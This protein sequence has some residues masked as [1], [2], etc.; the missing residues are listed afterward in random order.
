L[1]ALPDEWASKGSVKG[2]RARGNLIVDFSWANG[3]VTDYRVHGAS[4]KNTV[5]KFGHGRK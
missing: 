5:V 4:A 2:L 1:P 3:K